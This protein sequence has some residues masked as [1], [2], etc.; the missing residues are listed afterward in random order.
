M[1]LT[2]PLIFNTWKNEKQNVTSTSMRQ[3]LRDLNS[4]KWNQKFR[5]RL[6]FR[7]PFW[8]SYFHVQQFS[9]SIYNGKNDVLFTIKFVLLNIIYIYTISCFL[10]IKWNFQVRSE[11]TLHTNDVWYTYQN[12]IQITCSRCLSKIVVC[13]F[14]TSAYVMLNLIIEQFHTKTVTME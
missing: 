3:I 10:W 8:C 1:H 13:H 14:I 9:C 7:R 4:F 2:A 11:R 5:F 12:H 6:R